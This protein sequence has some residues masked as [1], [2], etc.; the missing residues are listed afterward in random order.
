MLVGIAACVPDT[1]R[2]AQQPEQLGPPVATAQRTTGAIHVDGRLDEPDWS[3]ALPI[4][5]LLQREPFEQQPAT[6][7][8]EIRILFDD[9]AL[10]F[11]VVCRDREPKSI[12]STQ[13]T[14][15]ADLEVDDLITIVLDPFFDHRNGFY[16]QVNPAA[17]R[18]DGQVSNNDERLNRDWEGSGLPLPTSPLMGGSPR[19]RFP[20]RR[21]ASSRASPYGA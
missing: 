10:Y 17:A 7:E 3:R 20:S 4:G 14:R 13:L 1:A 8:T 9:A 11:G 19:F 16:F 5:P 21:C 12:V 2:A 6:E 18:T 15:D